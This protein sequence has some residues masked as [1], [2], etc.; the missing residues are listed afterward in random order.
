MDRLTQ[1]F[2]QFEKEKN[3]FGR[4]Y[5]GVYYW[6]IIRLEVR[7]TIIGSRNMNDAVQRKKKKIRRYIVLCKDFLND[8]INYYHLKKC[9][10]LYFDQGIPGAYRNVDGKMKDVYLGYFGYEDKYRFERCYYIKSSKKNPEKPG[11]GT[12][13]IMPGVL[14]FKIQSL[15]NPQKFTDQREE[16]FIHNLCNEINEKYKKNISADRM[17]QNVRW[18]CAIRRIY[19]KFY[20]KLLSKTTPKTIIIQCHYDAVLYP[21]YKIA[22][23]FSIPVIELQ[24]GTVCDHM[25]YNYFDTSEK[26]KELPDYLFTYG[27]FWEKYMQLPAGIKMI[28]IGNP[29]LEAMKEKYKEAVLNEKAIVFYSSSFFFDGEELEKLAM[30]F[31]KKYSDKG[32]IIYFKFHPGEMTIWKQRYRLLCNCKE[33]QIVDPAMNVYQ[34]L[35]YAKHHVFVA[36]TVMYE[37][38]NYDICR[39]VYMFESDLKDWMLEKQMPLIEKG[40]GTEFHN[41]EELKD[42]IDKGIKSNVTLTDDVWKPNAKKNGQKALKKILNLS[43]VPK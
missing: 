21:L 18:L 23:E 22:K 32:Y 29:F 19:E 31:C 7:D 9:D 1:D 2:L 12:D 28:S 16:F 10:I 30:D 42:L 4:K 15:M 17:I 27:P 5:C 11:I 24:H 36:S 43:Y 14:I 37:A 20:R 39:Y 34:L 8:V 38:M 33:I 13:L 26:G 25:A 6:Q 41:A 35:A 3:L 40:G